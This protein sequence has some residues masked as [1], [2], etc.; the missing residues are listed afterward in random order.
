MIDKWNEYWKQMELTETELNEFLEGGCLSSIAITKS[1]R[2]LAAW[3][4]QKSLAHELDQYITPVQPAEV[5]IPF[6][7]PEFSEMWKRWKEYLLEQHG[8]LIKSRSEISA[9]EHLKKISRSNDAKAIDYL[10]FAMANRYRNFFQVDDKDTKQP[11]Q[12]DKPTSAFD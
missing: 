9:L 12:G 4:K 3:N 6:E 11:A 5:E 10:R 8:Q 7:S 1:K 2:F